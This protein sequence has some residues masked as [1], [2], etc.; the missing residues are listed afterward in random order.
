MSDVPNSERKL[1]A[2]N[3]TLP[4]GSEGVVGYVFWCPGCEMPHVYWTKLSKASQPEQ[5]IW[6]FNGDLEKPTFSPSLLMYGTEASPRCHLFLREGRLEFVGDSQ[7]KLAG[8]VVD[9][10]ALPEGW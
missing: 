4:D 3:G 6:S 10:P 9:L 5:P 8:Q 1:G 2:I 7:H